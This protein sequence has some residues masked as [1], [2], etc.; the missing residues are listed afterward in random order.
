M[1]TQ[2]RL[3]TCATRWQVGDGGDGRGVACGADGSGKERGEL[4]SENLDPL[5]GNQRN[6]IAIGT[7]AILMD[8]INIV[9][10]RES[11][12]LGV[13]VRRTYSDGC[14]E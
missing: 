6:Q 10:S 14:L 7:G 8:G 4:P 9:F 13:S 12:A 2:C 11:V 1:A 3:E 5:V